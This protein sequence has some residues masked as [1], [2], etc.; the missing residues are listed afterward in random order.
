V[1]RARPSASYLK[2]RSQFLCA[3]A[4]TA[5]VGLVAKSYG[6]ART[7]LILKRA[8]DARILKIA[9]SVEPGAMINCPK[10]NA[11]PRSDGCRGVERRRRYV[12]IVSSSRAGSKQIH[13]ATKINARWRV[14]RCPSR[15]SGRTAWRQLAGRRGNPKRR[16]SAWGVARRCDRHPL[17]NGSALPFSEPW[18]GQPENESPARMRAPVARRAAEILAAIAHAS[19][20]S[21][22]REQSG[23]D[24]DNARAAKVIDSRR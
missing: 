24:S 19:R 14:Y 6:A 1:H 7:R 12:R 18:S 5:A 23:A 8:I 15:A 4:Y 2:G 16:S 9:Q 21:A 22:L 13:I 10:N 3:A 11:T 20:P 17:T